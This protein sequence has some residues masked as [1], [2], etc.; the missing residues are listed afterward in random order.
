MSN[1]RSTYEKKD[2]E[3]SIDAH[4]KMISGGTAGAKEQHSAFSEK[5]KSIV[6]GGLDGI[7]T[8]FAV[9]SGA[10][11]GGFGL[12]VILGLGFATMF[13]DALSM[14]MG[15]ALSTKAEN[16]AV[17]KERKR[18]AWEFENFPEGEVQ[19]HSARLFSPKLPTS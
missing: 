18:E 1:I 13:A 8:T 16:S 19:L 17:M 3:A 6:Y 2:G 9:V 12:D 14:G 11:G 5:M 4:K 10:S 7:I 15:D